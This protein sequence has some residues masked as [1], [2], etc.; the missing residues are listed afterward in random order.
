MGVGKA[1][2]S[3]RPSEQEDGALDQEGPSRSSHRRSVQEPRHSRGSADAAVH[4]DLMGDRALDREEGGGEFTFDISVRSFFSRVLFH[5]GCTPYF[6]GA[7]QL[8]A[9]PQP[10]TPLPASSQLAAGT[11][12]P[13]GVS[14]DR[15]VKMCVCMRECE[16]AGSR[17]CI[18]YVCFGPRS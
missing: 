17:V 10:L 13:F 9:P 3:V 12:S 18:V 8:R 15:C 6:F 5:S 7:A 16:R 14:C 2:E 4:V 1:A 11:V